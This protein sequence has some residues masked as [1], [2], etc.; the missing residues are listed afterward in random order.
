MRLRNP[1]TRRAYGRAIRQFFDWLGHQAVTNL[2]DV[3]P[4]HVSA[5]LD[6]LGAERSIPTVK[7]HLAAIRHLFDWL[8]AGHVTALNPAHA[9]HGPTY[10]VERGKTPILTAQE[11][12]HLLDSIETDTLVGLRDRALIATMVFGF[13]RIG[14]AT[15]LTVENVFTQNR[16]LNLRLLE[17]RTTRH[18]IAC[19][20]TLEAYLVAYLDRARLWGHPQL[21]VFQTF[22]RTGCQPHG[23]DRKLS[24]RPLPQVSAFVIVRR[25]A[26][27]A[28]IATAIGNHTFRATG[29]TAHLKAGG[30]LEKARVMAAH[31]ST[32]TTQLYDRRAEEATLDEFEK[33]QI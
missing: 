6:D 4:L 16:R 19:H 1:R 27:A 7:A 5:F 31:R 21:P 22:L 23:E 12:R 32:K 3:Q 17:K 13:V 25:R 10:V 2:Q 28:G 15:T 30:T 9:V 24:G 20:H 11:T 14:A 8:T 29:I 26:K 33:I 18:D